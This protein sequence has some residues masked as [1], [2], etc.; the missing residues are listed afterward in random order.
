MT[1]I[2]VEGGKGNKNVLV[3]KFSVAYP[4]LQHHAPTREKD[5]VS[6]GQNGKGKKE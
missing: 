6:R 5:T 1:V 3:L 2:S 4:L